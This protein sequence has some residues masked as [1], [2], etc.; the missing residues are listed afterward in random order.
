MKSKQHVSVIAMQVSLSC[1][2][3]VTVNGS[4]SVQRIIN[5]CIIPKLI[6]SNTNTKK[7]HCKFVIMLMMGAKRKERYNKMSVIMK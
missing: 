1:L 7:L 5:S 4:S 3:I 2:S 6:D